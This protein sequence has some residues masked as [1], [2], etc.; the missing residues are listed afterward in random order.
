M[1]SMIASI[2]LVAAMLFLAEL[3]TDIGHAGGAGSHEFSVSVGSAAIPRLRHADDLQTLCIGGLDHLRRRADAVWRALPPFVEVLE[4]LL[5]AALAL[6]TS[7]L[8]NGPHPISDRGLLNLR[9]QAG[10][11]IL[12]RFCRFQLFHK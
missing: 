12:L 4:V 8:R 6:Q 3:K 10:C 9:V 5:I 2:S 7:G 1:K 11:R